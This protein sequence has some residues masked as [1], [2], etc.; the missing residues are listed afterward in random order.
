MFTIRPTSRSELS[1]A[2]A[3]DENRD[4]A[5]SVAWDRDTG[6]AWHEQVFED[7]AQEHLVGEIR[8]TIVGFA[9][10]GGVGSP[11]I[12]LRR[13]VLSPQWSGEGVA[14]MFLRELVDRAHGRYAAQ[15]VWTNIR[16]ADEE[17]RAFYAGEGFTL[18]DGRPS[19]HLA[20]DGS[21]ATLTVMTHRR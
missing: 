19:I 7:P 15:E 5:R 12:E 2:V 18:A 8:N 14:R 3:L 9:V 4:A 21:T 6:R 16:S 1:K 20:P 17:S 13:V 10:L 11:R